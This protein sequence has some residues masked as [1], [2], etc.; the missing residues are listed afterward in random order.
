MFFYGFSLERFNHYLVWPRL[1]ATI[2]CQAILFELMVDRRDR[3]T[4]LTFWF[5]VV[6]SV[7][8]IV[9]LSFY[10]ELAIQILPFSKASIVVISITMA[11]A[12]IHQI[13]LI[14][15]SGSTGGVALR[16]HQLTFIKDMGTVFFGLAM[17]S[18]SGW[19]LVLLGGSNSIFKLII[20]YLFHWVRVSSKASKRR[21]ARP[22][23]E[24]SSR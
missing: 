14:I 16:S 10:R 8:G 9:I 19:P 21:K 2:L 23:L 18:A 11:Q 15:R 4:R 20:M 5:C 17:G 3:R 12:N 22:I 13:I 6:A 1:T 7:C 24:V